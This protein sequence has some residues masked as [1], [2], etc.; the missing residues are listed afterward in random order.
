V[1]LVQVRS[2]ANS[3][4]RPFNPFRDLPTVTLLLARAFGSELKLESAAT[5]RFLRWVVRFPP[6]AWIWPGFEAWFD[7]SLAGFVWVEDGRV[8]GN[9]NVAPLSSGVGQW[10]LSN[11]VVAPSFRG[12]GIGRSLVETCLEHVSCQGGERVL[13][14]VWRSNAVAVHL[15]ESRGFQTMGHMWRLTL[16]ADSR[17]VDSHPAQCPAGWSWRRVKAADNL[18]LAGLAAS[19]GSHQVQALRPSAVTV[20]RRDLREL[21]GVL[22]AW[23]GLSDPPARRVLCEGASV[24]AA[25]ASRP[26]WG[27]WQRLTILL[28]PSAQE[29]AAPCVA[30]QAALMASSRRK[31]SVVCDLPDSMPL[32]RDELLS[33]G[34]IE[35]DALLQ[36]TLELGSRVR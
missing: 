16:A 10:V 17:A 23:V 20:F 14:Q 4:L 24:R 6:L 27:Q 30:A 12:R 25:V 11:V 5:A 1:A 19:M 28:S 3:G 36:M 34:F 13:L 33:V 8:V 7:S 2:S 21:P 22:S 18:A 26:G 15:Y 9:A 29:V 32:L 35:T 31:R